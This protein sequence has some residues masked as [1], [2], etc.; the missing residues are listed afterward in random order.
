M[1]VYPFYF[2]ARFAD[3][4]LLTYSERESKSGRSVLM[5]F[6]FLVLIVWYSSL[7]FEFIVPILTSYNQFLFRS[8]SGFVG[9]IFTHAFR[10]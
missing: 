7:Y 8:N 3:F 10:S 4:P 9:V 2:L 6:L 1:V 5:T